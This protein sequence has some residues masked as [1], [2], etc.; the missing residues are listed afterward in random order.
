MATAKRNGSLREL[1]ELRDS[2]RD[3]LKE[4]PENTNSEEKGY[5]AEK[6]GE[7]KNRLWCEGCPYTV[8]S[9]TKDDTKRHLKTKHI[10]ETSPTT[11]RENRKEKKIE[12]A[13]S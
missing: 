12:D 4:P 1:R 11:R 6:G 7:E 2:L 13:V 10:A 8:E 5:K 9:S 3:S